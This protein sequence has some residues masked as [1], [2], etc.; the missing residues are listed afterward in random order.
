M[1]SGKT[2]RRE[3]DRVTIMG[4]SFVTYHFAAKGSRGPLTVHWYDNGLR[5]P[6]PADLDPDDP[7]QRLGEGQDGLLIVGEKGYVTCAGW[8]GMPRLLP[9]AL[10]QSYRARPKR[11]LVSPGIMPTGCRRARAG[12]RRAATS[13][14]ARASPSSS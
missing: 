12:H 7:R 2:S 9:M 6:K 10:H 11:F 4:S 13:S 1:N 14:T 5:P 3:N 8:S